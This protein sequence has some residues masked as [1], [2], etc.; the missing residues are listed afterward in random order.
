MVDF[1]FFQN[2]GFG[3]NMDNMTDGD[4]YKNWVKDNKG[5]IDAG[6][7]AIQIILPHGHDIAAAAAIKWFREQGW[8][9][10]QVEDVSEELCS[11]LV[12]S[13]KGSRDVVLDDCARIF[14][15]TASVA[16]V[17]IMAHVTF[18]LIGVKVAEE[19]M[20]NHS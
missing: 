5:K 8:G 16:H 11:G 15:G 9:Q 1:N 10:K 13:C 14:A 3:W 17:A 12:R 20:N 7:A 19:I 6:L 18:A 4:D 2:S